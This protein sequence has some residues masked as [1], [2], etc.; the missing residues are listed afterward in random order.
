MEEIES[1]DVLQFRDS[2]SADLLAEMNTKH[3]KSRLLPIVTV[4]AVIILIILAFLRV[5]TW[6]YAIAVPILG[7]AI[8]LIHYRDQ[9]AKTTILFYELDDSVEDAYQSLHD[10]FNGLAG[11]IRIWH[12]A[13]AGEVTDLDTWKRQ[14]GASSMVRRDSVHLS[15]QSPP[16]VKTNLSVPSI[17]AGKHT[18]YFFP[19]RILVY[20]NDRIG[21]VSYPDIQLESGNTRF[22]EEPREVPS[23]AQ[24]VD[25]T[26]QYVNKKGGPDRRFKD[27]RELP[28]ALYS[29][30]HF[31]SQTG[32]NYVFQVSKPDMGVPLEN[33]F[34]GIASVQS[35]AGL[36]AD[37]S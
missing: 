10:A 6:L 19:D 36:D 32:L 3:R 17:P 15:F 28:I 12:I 16:Y 35:E 21:A 29:N 18:L 24:I 4:F 26:W 5:S 27:N 2:S 37:K 8:L 7:Y 1:A 9:L 23:D 20:E 30:L 34:G 11:C 25:H 22:I 14:A 31:K 33:A 13:A